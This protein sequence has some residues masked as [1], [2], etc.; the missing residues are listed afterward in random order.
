M[1]A[2]R[3]LCPFQEARSLL[4]KMNPSEDDTQWMESRLLR[5]GDIETSDEKR[6]H[7]E[8]CVKITDL[9]ISVT[10]LGVFKTRAWELYEN[11]IAVPRMLSRKLSR[12]LTLD[13]P[14]AQPLLREEP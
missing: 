7:A 6:A 8:V 14:G 4:E 13:T 11:L 12:E 5:G 3:M 2:Q 1:I 9:A 10:Q